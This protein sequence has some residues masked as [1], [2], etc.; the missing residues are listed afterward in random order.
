MT[1][2]PEN[3]LKLLLRHE[4][5]VNIEIGFQILKSHPEKTVFATH[6]FALAYYHANER[7]RQK[8]RT[9]FKQM[10]CHNLREKVNNLYKIFARLKAQ[11]PQNPKKTEQ[12]VA[13]Y[14]AQV[15]DFEIIDKEELGNLTMYFTGMGFRFC[16]EHH[17][18]F[19]PI[20]FVELHHLDLSGCYDPKIKQYLPYFSSITS[21]DLSENQLNTFPDEILSLSNLHIL[22][23]SK[24]RLNSLPASISSLS[25]LQHLDA[26]ENRLKKLPNSIC[27][28]EDLHYLNLQQNLLQKLPNNIGYLN[29]LNTLD[30]SH[31]LLAEFPYSMRFF[32]ECDTV[33]LNNNLLSPS[34]WASEAHVNLVPHFWVNE[35]EWDHEFITAQT[36]FLL[37][38]AIYSHIVPPTDWNT[39]QASEICYTE[40]VLEDNLQKSTLE[41]QWMEMASVVADGQLDKGEKT[42]YLQQNGWQSLSNHL[43]VPTHLDGQCMEFYPDDDW[44]D[45]LQTQSQIHSDI[46]PWMCETGMRVRYL[47]EGDFYDDGQI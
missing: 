22:N 46:W 47:V 26:S 27:Q 3:N 37:D 2:N 19:W 40:Q 44:A 41:D 11:H 15:A 28:I 4:E 30:V 24:N 7:I 12:Q 20:D 35:G 25:M 21:V 34:T 9:L 29:Y 45:F 39:K 42:A 14:L 38:E 5:A 1:Q 33:H 17:L 18:A 32:S 43:S 6:L 13:R 16:W 31:N 36:T 8:A 23:I 10:A